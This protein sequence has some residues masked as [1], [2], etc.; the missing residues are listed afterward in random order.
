MISNLKHAED[1]IED[2]KTALSGWGLDPIYFS[3]KNLD[4]L[5]LDKV[6]EKRPI[7]ILHAS[8]HKLNV[9]SLGLKLA[10][11]LRTGINHDGL[12]LGKDGIP[13]GEIR[14]AETIALVTKHVGLGKDWLS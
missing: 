7:G 5:I 12:P 1:K 8:G 2:A 9:N 10:G 14:G 3:N 13:T 4:R 11:F 6:S